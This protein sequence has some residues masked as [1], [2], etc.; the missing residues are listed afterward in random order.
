MDNFTYH[1]PTKILF[2]RGQIANLSAEIPESARIMLTY[3]GGSIRHNGVYEQVHKAL[4]GRVVVEFGGIEPN[5]TFET[6]MKAVAVVRE[7]HVDFMLAVGGGSVIDGTKFIAAAVRFQ[8]DP[9][10]I[11]AKRVPRVRLHDAIPLGCVLT[12]PATGSEMNAN[13]VISRRET[14]DKLDFSSPVVVPRFS[15]L[16][17]TTTFSLPPRQVANGVVDAFV[18]VTEQYLTFPAEAMIQDQFAE[19]ILRTLIAMGPRA[20]LEPENYAVRANLMWAATMALN[21]LIGVGVPQD[22]ATHMIGHEL[23]ARFGLD[24]ARTLAVVLPALLLVR[25]REKHAK[26]LQ[27]AANVWGIRDGDEGLRI[28]RAIHATRD[29]FERLWVPTHLSEYGIRDA[30]IPAILSKLKEHG[31]TAIGE[32]HDVTPDTVQRILKLAA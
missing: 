27:Y 29:F 8:G 3:G 4:A 10:E 15:V 2:G 19:S 11:L 13:A 25:R 12:L 5:P 6:L 31:M 24:H 28:E 20:L 17:P 32:R 26:L 18:H 21:G 30:E 14:G 16:D 23:T 1:A 9:W 7:E 22:W